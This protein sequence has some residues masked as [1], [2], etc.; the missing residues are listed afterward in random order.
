MCR[1]LKLSFD[2]IKDHVLQGV[3]SRELAVFALSNKHENEN[4][5]LGD[6]LEWER[7]NALRD[8]ISRKNDPV[9]KRNEKSNYSSK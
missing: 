6:L 4:E 1:E 9:D 8:G 5:L 2:E 3:Y 7:L